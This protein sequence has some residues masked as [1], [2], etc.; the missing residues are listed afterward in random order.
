LTGCATKA[1]KESGSGPLSPAATQAIS[2]T[3]EASKN[4]KGIPWVESIAGIVASVGVIVLAADRA[5]GKL[6][7]NGNGN[8]QTKVT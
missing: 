6:R 2:D 3:I 4:A 1:E 8:T 5:I 7:S